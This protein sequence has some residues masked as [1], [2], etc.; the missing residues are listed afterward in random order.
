[1]VPLFEDMP[2]IIT[3]AMRGRRYVGSR[4]RPAGASDVTTSSRFWDLGLTK[5]EIALLGLVAALAAAMHLGPVLHSGLGTPLL[6]V[7][8]AVS[9]LSPVSGFF[10]VACGQFLPFP[11]GSPHNPAQAAVLVWIPMVLLR[12]HRLS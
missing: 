9:Y 2:Q 4:R 6:Y 7:L 1:M 12:Y 5:A 8:A 3:T 10:F 11:E